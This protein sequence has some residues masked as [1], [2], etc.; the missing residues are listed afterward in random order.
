[1]SFAAFFWTVIGAALGS[2]GSFVITRY[3]A[4]KSDQQLLQ[5]SQAFAQLAE[6]RG[7]I[8]WTRDKDGRITFG[9]V[10]KVGIYGVSATGLVGTPTA[11]I[12]AQPATVEA[13]V[14]VTPKR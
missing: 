6:D 7:L 5:V 3:F 2:A 1:M 9:K 12:Q 13:Q 14:D 4:R 8:E 11:S 10:V